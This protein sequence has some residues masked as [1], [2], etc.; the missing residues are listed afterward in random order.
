MASHS[1]QTIVVYAAPNEPYLF[2]WSFDDFTKFAE[3]IA[4]M[5]TLSPQRQ[6]LARNILAAA[7]PVAVDGDGRVMLPTDICQKVGITDKIL[8]AGQGEFFTLWNPEKYE[9]V[10]VTDAASYE[11][12]LQI[13]NDNWEALI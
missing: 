7:K 11:D 4:K 1:R 3:R 2:G 8:F 9:A 5:P 13:L 6:R 12:D 10:Q